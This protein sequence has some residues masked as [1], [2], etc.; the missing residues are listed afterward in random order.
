LA[1]V[2][3]SQ[4]APFLYAKVEFDDSIW[5]WSF[6]VPS[7]VGHNVPKMMIHLPI[8]QKAAAKKK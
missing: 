3:F 5:Q 2:G 4:L 1:N 6:G 8:C 7:V